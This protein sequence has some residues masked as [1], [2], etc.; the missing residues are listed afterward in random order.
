MDF[1]VDIE[2]QIERRAQIIA[3]FLQCL[4]HAAD[5]RQAL[6]QFGRKRATQVDHAGE[7]Q[8]LC[9]AHD[10]R[11]AGERLRRQCGRRGK[12]NFFAIFL[13]DA[14]DA[15]FGRAHLVQ[16][17]SDALVECGSGLHGRTLGFDVVDTQNAPN[18]LQRPVWPAAWNAVAS[19]EF[20]HHEH[21]GSSLDGGLVP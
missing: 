2:G 17:R 9:R 14:G 11:V 21:C 13:K 8:D 4:A 16:L 15:L 18:P 20:R 3:D 19:G 12:E 6:F 5:N 7:A 10:C 1:D